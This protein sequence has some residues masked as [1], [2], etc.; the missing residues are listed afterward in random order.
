MIDATA[1]ATLGCRGRATSI[2]NGQAKHYGIS[3]VGLAKACRRM[4][5][6]RPPVGYWA[7]RAAGHEIEIPSL[8]LLV[9]LQIQSDTLS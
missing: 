7:K 4:G 5:V 8:P 2:E 1:Q 9:K 6:P 3:D